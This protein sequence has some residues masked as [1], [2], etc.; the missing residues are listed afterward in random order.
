MGM[1]V[2]RCRTKVETWL[3]DTPC[4]SGAEEGLCYAPTALHFCLHFL[5]RL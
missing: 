5:S 4:G 1:A 3:G 2:R